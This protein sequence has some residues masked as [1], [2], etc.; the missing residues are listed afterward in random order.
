MKK[1][2]F[3]YTILIIMIL[4]TASKM[5]RGIFDAYTSINRENTFQTTYKQYRILNGAYEFS[6]PSDWNLMEQNFGGGE[7][8]YHGD[9]FSKDN[10]T[11]GIVEVW[12]IN[13]P[14]INFLKNSQ[15]SSTGVVEFKFY[16]ILPYKIG[17]N[18]GYLVEYSRKGTDDKYYRALE[19][20]I[21]SKNNR[22]F[23]MSFYIPENSYNE[24]LKQYLENI[25]LRTKV[26]K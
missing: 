5:W 8:E 19:Y 7:I 6:L 10:K 16:K 2:H 15:L 23:R 4:I 26:I 12:N 18:D 9:F 21:P 11:K 25:V 1:I 3:L 20:F 17:N 22:F 14:L 24:T 13:M